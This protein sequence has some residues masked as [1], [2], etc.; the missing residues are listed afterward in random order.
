MSRE[1]IHIYGPFSIQSFGF[2]IAVGLAVFTWLVLSHPSRKKLVTD[3]QFS[4]G[5]MLGIL[6]GIIGGRLLYVFQDYHAMTSIWEPLYFWEGG[7][8]VLGTI[9]AVLLV[10]GTYLY[11]IKVPVLQLFDL[12]CIYAP[13]FQSISRIGCFLAGCCYGLPTAL[14]WGITYTDPHSSAPLCI[15]LHPTQ[16]YSSLIL[17]CIFLFIRFGVTRWCTIP[18]HIT[19]VYLALAGMERFIVDFWRDDRAYFQTPMFNMLSMYQWMALGMVVG[20]ALVFGIITMWA[21][22]KSNS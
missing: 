14:P 10:V 21:H 4:T 9:F 13:L 2:M 5:L 22:R 17:L 6:S 1:L 16:L 20:A 11:K 8:S 3:E 18:G 7:F 12:L 15:A 19:C